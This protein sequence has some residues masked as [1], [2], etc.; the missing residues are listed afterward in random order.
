MHKYYCFLFAGL[1]ACGS[2]GCANTSYTMLKPTG[3]TRTPEQVEI[4]FSQ[5]TSETTEVGL[6]T[7]KT[8]KSVH[9]AINRAR[10]KA[11]AYGADGIYLSGGTSKGAF[12]I[13]DQLSAH[14]TEYMFVAFAL[15][16]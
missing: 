12:Q 11:A 7:V 6:I 1:I 9:T 8:T 15:A 2:L 3:T 5:P 14:Q 16:K 13:N 4:H 10:K